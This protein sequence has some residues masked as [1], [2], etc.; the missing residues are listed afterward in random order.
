MS[1]EHG[2]DAAGPNAPPYWS[3]FAFSMASSMVPTM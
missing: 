2:N 1:S 3:F